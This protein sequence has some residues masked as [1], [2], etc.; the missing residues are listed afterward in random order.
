MPKKAIIRQKNFKNL[1]ETGIRTEIKATQNLT[2]NQNV[3]RR[4][5]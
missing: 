5:K 3:G 2:K 1:A 4:K